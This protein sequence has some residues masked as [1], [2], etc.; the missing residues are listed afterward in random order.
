[1][2][3]VCF[4]VSLTQQWRLYSE[5][6]QTQVMEPPLCSAQTLGSLPATVTS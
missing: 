3:L 5:D 4:R 2:L 1:M 6:S